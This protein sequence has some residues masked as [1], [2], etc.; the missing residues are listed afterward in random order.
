[1]LRDLF[2]RVYIRA[3]EPIPREN[4]QLLLLVGAAMFIAGYDVNIYGFAA[5]QIQAS[6]SIPEGDI[7]KVIAVFRM[8]II[9]AIG[10]AYLADRIGRRNLLMLTL[11]GAAVAT[12]WTAFASTLTEFLI[13]QTLARVCIY[14]EEILCVVVIAEEFSERT[15]GWAIGQ[16][17]AL[18]ALGAG[19]AAIVFG[20]VS[21]L[22]FGWRAIY[23]L[24]AAPLLWLLWAR[25]A[26]P[27][28]KRFSDRAATDTIRPFASLMRNYPGRLALLSAAAATNSFAMAATVTLFSSFLQGTHHWLPWQVAAL[29]ISAGAFA[30]LGNTVAGTLSDRHGRKR[31]LA[32]AVVAAS[33][34]FASFYGWADGLWLPL[35]WTIGLF[36]VLATDI[37]IA[38]LGAELFPTSHRTLASSVRFAA[39]LGGGVIGFLVEA[40]VFH[41]FQSH[42]IAI[43]IM[44]LTA[45]ICLVPIW[46]LP[47][48]AGKTLEE[49]SGER[50]Q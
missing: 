43:A 41:A 10:L 6:F 27:E 17:G 21:I 4:R 44:A 34:C 16:L 42:G 3:P 35:F 40:E 11:A 12:V 47:E 38:G 49:I 14:T 1:M 23:F 19:A 2:R 30:I 24:G 5:R 46:F 32:S 48:S 25:R 45:P 37:L 9:P 28:T 15:R 31:V 26:L 8:G 36:A 7:G 33:I 20:F 39:S 18:G 29:T 13:A 50:V 22:P